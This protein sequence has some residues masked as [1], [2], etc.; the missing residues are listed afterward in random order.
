MQLH[1]LERSKWLKDKMRRKGRWNA[2]KGNTAGR[3]N[4]WQKSRSGYSQKPFFEGWQ[5][6]LFKRLPKLRGFKRYY[7]LIEDIVGINVSTLDSDDRIV[8]T[9]DTALLQKLGYCKRWESIK[10]LWNGEISKKIKIED[11]AYFS[12]SARAK[13]EKAWGKITEKV[14]EEKVETKKTK[15]K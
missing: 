10:I 11:I 1:E 5:T 7:K 6:P 13:I 4:N 3:W 8:D 15:D 2:S 9:L 12:K 14:V